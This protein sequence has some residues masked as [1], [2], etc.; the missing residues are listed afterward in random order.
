[1]PAASSNADAEAFASATEE[2]QDKTAQQ[3]GRYM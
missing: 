3:Q 1:M 2:I